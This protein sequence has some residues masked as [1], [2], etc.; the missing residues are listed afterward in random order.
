ME[1]SPPSHPTSSI[2]DNSIATNRR[3]YA[4]WL[5]GVGLI[6]FGYQPAFLSLTF[7]SY[8]LKMT[9]CNAIN[10]LSL[11]LQRFFDEKIQ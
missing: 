3:P 4:T 8:R 5:K 11:A 7:F 6:V 2:V 10:R 1:K 9:F